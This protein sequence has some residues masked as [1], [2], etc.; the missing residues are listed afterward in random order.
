M[1][2]F[3]T[4]RAAARSLQG[5]NATMVSQVKNKRWE[6]IS[7]AQWQTLA[8]Q[9]GFY[10]GNEWQQAD[11]SACLLLRILF[12]D[13]QY[14][15][16][17]YGVAMETGIGKTFTATRYARENDYTHYIACNEEMNRKVFM[18]AL[19]QSI[20]LETNNTVE[21]MMEQILS[22]LKK[23]E[24]LLLVLDD[25]HKLKDRVLQFAA[26]LYR[27]L[28]GR[29]GIVMLG[30]DEL[31]M[32]IIEGVRLNKEGYEEIYRNIGRR[33]I[34]L[35][36]LSEKDVALVCRA[37]GLRDEGSISSITDTCSSNLHRATALIQELKEKKKNNKI[38]NEPAKNEAL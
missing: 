7:D 5:V 17:A 20:G 6:F 29:C 12:N 14:N 2:G 31:R 8:R 28:A 22:R 33:F 16:M 35:G 34:T 36:R 32:R 37:N 25:A 38:I 4:Q 10:T 21:E 15:A 3:E 19:A 24:E 26:T 9:V 23:N 13:A 1:T 30:N 11:T 27:H 18:Q